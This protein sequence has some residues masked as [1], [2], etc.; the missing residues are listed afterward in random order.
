V[1]IIIG[2]A[3]AIWWIRKEKRNEYYEKEDWSKIS[4]DII[5]RLD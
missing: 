2:I 5:D 1:E 3:I 4:K